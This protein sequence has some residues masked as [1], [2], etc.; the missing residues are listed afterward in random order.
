MLDLGEARAVSVAAADHPGLAL[1][2]VAQDAGALPA[3]QVLVA[4]AAL[5]DAEVTLLPHELPLPQELA[6][7]NGVAATLRWDER[8]QGARGE[9]T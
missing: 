2:A 7:A 3:D 5:T 9:Q 8:P 4:A 6:L 1:P